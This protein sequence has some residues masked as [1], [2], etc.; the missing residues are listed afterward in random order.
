MRV[1]G[2]PRRHANHVAAPDFG[3]ITPCVS[4]DMPHEGGPAWIKPSRK[5]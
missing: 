4:R 5:K 1:M 2:K 3:R